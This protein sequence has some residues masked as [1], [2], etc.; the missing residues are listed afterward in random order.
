[1]ELA[2]HRWQRRARG[3]LAVTCTGSDRR[4]WV[5]DSQVN[6]PGAGGAGAYDSDP[7]PL[8][9]R[10]GGRGAARHA[11]QAGRGRLA[12]YGLRLQAE[13]ISPGP[14]EATLT[15]TGS[16]GYFFGQLDL[17]AGDVQFMVDAI[18]G[19]LTLEYGP[20]RSEDAERLLAEH[21]TGRP[22]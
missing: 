15:V 21:R 5:R 22:G 20:W 6:G 13:G 17:D 10:R 12:L 2:S 7:L 11:G 9:R 3:S 8:A 1:M 16:H 4:A 19:M 14:V 18:S